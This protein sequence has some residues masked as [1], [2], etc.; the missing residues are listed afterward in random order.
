[1][2]K[3]MKSLWVLALTALCFTAPVFAG[4]D[5]FF[6]GG[7]A[8]VF[9][10]GKLLGD[11]WDFD[12][13]VDVQNQFEFGVD[14]DIQVQNLP[15]HIALGYLRGSSDD[16][17]LDVTTSELRLGVRKYFDMSDY[18]MDV[19]VGGGVANVMGEVKFLGVSTDD[20]GIGFYVEVAGAY[21]IN[22]QFHVGAKVDYS[23]ADID[24]TESGGIHY[25]IFAG[26]SF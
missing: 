18:S 2:D 25:G 1:M 12:G 8:N 6:N 21:K 26:M 23:L 11:D 13:A 17:G 3:Y 20:T 15:F 14:G 4:M 19:F 5:D 22:E 24:G 9:L 16:S 7:H 10:G